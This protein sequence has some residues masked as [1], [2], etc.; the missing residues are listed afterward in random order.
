MVADDSWRT[1]DALAV[2]DAIL[3]L[4]DRA[5]AER[6]FRDLCT[7]GETARHG[8]PLAVA[9]LST[10][11]CTTPR[12]AADRREHRDDHRI[13]S[14]L[15]HGEGGYRLDARPTDGP[16]ARPADTPMTADDRLRLAVPTRAA[17]S[18]R[19]S[20][21][22]TTPAS[23]SRSTIEPRRARLQLRPRHPLRSHEP[24]SSTSSATASRTF[25]VT[26]ID[27]LVEAGAALPRVRSLGYGRCRLAAA[28]PL[29]APHRDRGAG[30]HP[31]RHRTSEHH[32]PLLPRSARSRSTSSRSP[33]PSGRA[34]ARPRGSHRRSRLDE[35]RR[36]R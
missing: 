22:S 16:G 19:P 2:F 18:S 24:T 34:P 26:G 32:P 7:L 27:L 14:W 4:E 13:A 1:D 10:R 11:A 36:W 9:R 21:C 3:A 33:A 6:F 12:S 17:S 20:P 31:R 5:E 15:H 8:P 23:S 28:V 29:D 35:A 25:G 30:R